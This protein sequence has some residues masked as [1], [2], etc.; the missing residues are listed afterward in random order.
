MYRRQQ[1]RL[2]QGRGRPGSN[3]MDS[4]Y[5]LWVPL[6]RPCSWQLL[7]GM[8]ETPI[9]QAADGAGAFQDWLLCQ[10]GSAVLRLGFHERSGLKARVARGLGQR[11]GHKYASFLSK[12]TWQ[13]TCMIWMSPSPYR[14]Q[15]VT[16]SSSGNLTISASTSTGGIEIC[17]NPLYKRR[18]W[19]QK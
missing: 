11:S 1:A 8:S 3:L 14:S 9:V 17:M 16:W 13:W 12:R 10:S 5:T 7:V 15:K 4:Y 19:N 2:E 6:R 18:D